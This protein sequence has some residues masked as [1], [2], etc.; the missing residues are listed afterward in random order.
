MLQ[1]RNRN[2]CDINMDNYTLNLLTKIIF[3]YPMNFLLSV[4]F[5][6][7]NPL[8]ITETF[9]LF[10]NTTWQFEMRNKLISRIQNIACK[11]IIL[12]VSFYFKVLQ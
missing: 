8:K 12:Y 11:K 1:L 2:R 3:S 7:S 5:K 6:I 4:P 10:S 9:L